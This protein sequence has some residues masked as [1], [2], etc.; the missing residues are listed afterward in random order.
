MAQA[1]ARSFEVIRIDDTPS[2]ARA[3][4]FACSS[5]SVGSASTQSRPEV[6]RPGKSR[7]R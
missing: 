1:P 7:S 6:K 5:S 2:P 3:G 4:R